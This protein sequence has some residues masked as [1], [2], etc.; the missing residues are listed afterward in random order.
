MDDHERKWEEMTEP[1]PVFF[2][3]F[4]PPNVKVSSFF[5]FFLFPQLFF[6]VL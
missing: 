1:E 5:L 4:P 3:G 6:H 2:H